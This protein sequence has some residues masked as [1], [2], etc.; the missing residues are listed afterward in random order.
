MGALGCSESNKQGGNRYT[1]E[2]YA[3]EVA[4][5]RVCFPVLFSCFAMRVFV[6]HQS[7]TRFVR[8]CLGF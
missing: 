3:W 2:A 5:V 8:G 7:T 6:F 4:T 1:D